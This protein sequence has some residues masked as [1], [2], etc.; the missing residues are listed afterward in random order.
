MSMPIVICIFVHPKSYLLLQ[1][2]CSSFLN[3]N[4]AHFEGIRDIRAFEYILH[5]FCRDYL[6]D[7]QKNENCTTVHFSLYPSLFL[8]YSILG[9]Q[10]Q[11]RYCAYGGKS[12]LLSK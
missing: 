8:Q 11:V 1:T 12:N 9:F 10:R 4:H 7:T 5:F 3:I 6:E 2:L